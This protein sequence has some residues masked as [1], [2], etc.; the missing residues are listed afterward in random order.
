MPG[1]G[2]ELPIR[3]PL[4]RASEPDWSAGK[5]VT[6]DNGV[7]LTFQSNG[8]IVLYSPQHQALWGTGT[9]A[10]YGNKDTAWDVDWSAGQQA[11]SIMGNQ[12]T[13]GGPSAP[14]VP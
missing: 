10:G 11:V 13:D 1:A 5:T 6:T 7:E 8:D 2:V 12:G 14:S 3:R 4:Q 9:D